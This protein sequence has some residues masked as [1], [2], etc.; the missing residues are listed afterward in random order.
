MIYV[1]IVIC[2]L[3]TLLL[4][5]IA[6]TLGKMIRSRED[7]NRD[8]YNAGFHKGRIAMLDAM[9]VNMERHRDIMP[10]WV[11]DW[12]ENLSLAYKKAQERESTL[13]DLPAKFEGH[14]DYSNVLEQQKVPSDIRL[15]KDE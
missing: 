3:N 4:L 6:G 5:G 10:A 2:L 13:M 8:N 14:V 12:V 7:G 11:I 15:L 9:R 1:L